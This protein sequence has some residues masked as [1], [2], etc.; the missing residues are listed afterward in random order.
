MGRQLTPGNVP[1]WSGMSVFLVVVDQSGTG[2][3]PRCLG[4]EGGSIFV[5]LEED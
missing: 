5:A 4:K 3:K 2:Y 1:F